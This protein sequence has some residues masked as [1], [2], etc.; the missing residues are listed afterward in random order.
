MPVARLCFFPFKHKPAKSP[1]DFPPSILFT[2]RTFTILFLFQE[3]LGMPLNPLF[4]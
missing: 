4:L 2:Y 3:L 1:E